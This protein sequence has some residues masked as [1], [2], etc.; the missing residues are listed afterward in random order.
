MINAE[1]C[2]N[3]ASNQLFQEL[4]IE[5]SHPQ[6]FESISKFLH[7][8]TEN[9]QQLVD[10]RGTDDH[11]IAESIIHYLHLDR[12]AHS[13]PM[14]LVAMEAASRMAH[15][16]NAILTTTAEFK[17]DGS[18]TIRVSLDRATMVRLPLLGIES[19]TF[20]QRFEIDILP[21]KITVFF[22]KAQ[23]ISGLGK[24]FV[25][26]SLSHSGWLVIDAKNPEH[27]ILDAEKMRAMFFV[28]PTAL[29]E[30]IELRD[31]ATEFA[32]MIY[33]STKDFALRARD[34]IHARTENNIWSPVN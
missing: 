7:G 19:P 13:N 22:A 27:I 29:P 14:M 33:P 21:D 16:R 18:R 10:V 12:E 23:T 1:A 5:H 31:F 3:V 25:G 8:E 20:S 11:Q 9:V 30:M 17:T 15:K 2:N 28:G 34:Q 6:S 24:T 26:D 32:R 4:L